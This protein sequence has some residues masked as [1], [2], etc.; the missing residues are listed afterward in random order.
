MKN[1]LVLTSLLFLSFSAF[2]G[3]NG[4]GGISCKSASKRTTIEGGAGVTYNGYGRAFIKLTVDGKSIN[5]SSEQVVSK[6][7]IASLDAVA[8]SQKNK[9]Y[10]LKIVESRELYQGYKDVVDTLE[11]IANP[12]T[13]KE[14]SRDVFQ[15]DAE[16]N[17]IDP[18]L[19][20][21]E[22]IKMLQNTIS[23]KCVL[24]LRV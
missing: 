22:D 19:D 9:I 18:R 2:A 24:D 16:L 7:G 5:L 21:N 1:T 13:F 8:F 15:F 6:K 12:S 23:L 17:G 4:G 20:Q 11:L 10:T 14:T 3:D